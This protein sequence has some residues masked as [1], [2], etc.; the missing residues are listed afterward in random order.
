VGITAGAQRLV[1]GEPDVDV[2]RQASRVAPAE[3]PAVLRG[4]LA[5]LVPPRLVASGPRAGMTA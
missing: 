5:E 2:E 3:M 1:V 4:L